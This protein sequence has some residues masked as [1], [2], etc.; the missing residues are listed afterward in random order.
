MS[1]QLLQVT[2]KQAHKTT[3]MRRLIGP[4]GYD[5][6]EIEQALVA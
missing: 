1:R 5:K 4:S 3:E 2:S 6:E